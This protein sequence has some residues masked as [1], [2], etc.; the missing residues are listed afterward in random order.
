MDGAGRTLLFLDLKFSEDSEL[1]SNC[2]QD[3]V[4]NLIIT[5]QYL[6]TNTWIAC[7]GSLME[8]EKSEPA[9]F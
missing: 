5:S 2:S 7:D 4:E 8:Y 9:E 3:P 1:I 6:L